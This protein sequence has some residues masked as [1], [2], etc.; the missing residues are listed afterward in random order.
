MKKLSFAIACA[1]GTATAVLALQAAAAAPIARDG[2]TASSGK[3]AVHRPDNR[4]GPLTK[5]WIERRRAALELVARGH[6]R[7][8]ANGNV[9]VDSE[10]NNVV[11]VA[12]EKTDKIFTILSEFGTQSAGRYGTVPG[13]V[14]NEIAEPDRSVDNS[15]IWTADFN[16]AHYEDLFNGS[17]ESMRTFY[18]Q[19]SSGKYSVSN[20]VS[21]W[22]RVP[23][24][25][26]Y[27]GDNAVED[28]GGAW[29]FIEDTGNAWYQNAVANGMSVADINAYLA[30][31]DVWDRNDFDNDGNY[32]EQDG[33]IDHFQAV[34]AGEGEEA[35]G[36]AQG[37][38]AIWS[39]RW[40]VN[41]TDYGVTG[42]T[43]GGQDDL[44]GGAR[45]GN[46]NYWIGDYTTEPENGGLGVFSH[47][48]GHDLGLPDFYDTNA[49]ENSTAFWTLMSSGS[50]ASER[51]LA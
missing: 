30:Q 48:F 40:Y 10:T 16:T 18:E 35:G 24:N 51:P 21:G 17:G 11:E 7:V 22:V 49:G 45:I 38:D 26:S 9:T 12:F 37:A 1:A 5:Q 23:H 28:A 44:A 42:P 4:P 33:Y 19:L 36:G 2:A 31:F 15:T 50:R 39:H 3:A 46:S 34:H 6:A 47:E 32:N 8:D 14:H 41:P 25:A 27:Y 29:Q 43:V 13:P 20:T